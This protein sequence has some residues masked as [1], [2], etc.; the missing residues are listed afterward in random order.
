VGLPF[1]IRG[2]KNSLAVLSASSRESKRRKCSFLDNYGVNIACVKENFFY[3]QIMV[4]LIDPTSTYAS[5]TAGLGAVFNTF[6]RKSKA[7]TCNWQIYR[8]HHCN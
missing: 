1:L 5:R 3:H 8:I 2:Y 7:V 4:Y 6:L